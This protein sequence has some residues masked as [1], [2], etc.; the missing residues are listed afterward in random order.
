MKQS[1]DWVKENSHYLRIRER[2]REMEV[3]DR[4]LIFR[5][6]MERKKTR[7]DPNR[8]TGILT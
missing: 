7:G 5:Y 6:F 8:K 4:N 3:N 2:K 1:V